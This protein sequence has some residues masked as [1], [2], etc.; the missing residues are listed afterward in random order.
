VSACGGNEHPVARIESRKVGI[1]RELYKASEVV[2]IWGYVD[3]ITLFGIVTVVVNPLDK[4][5]TNALFIP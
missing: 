2:R 3:F 4:D 1:I 5:M